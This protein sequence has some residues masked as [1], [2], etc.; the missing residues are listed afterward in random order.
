[1]LVTVRR[2]VLHCDRVLTES[3]TDI[4]TRLPRSLPEIFDLNS[5]ILQRM[6]KAFGK[7]TVLISAIGNNGESCFTSSRS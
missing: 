1:M 2:S 7:D 5:Y 3:L 6:R 4:D